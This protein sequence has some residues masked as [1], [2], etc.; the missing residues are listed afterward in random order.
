M[1]KTH[2][3]KSF[4]EVLLAT[5]GWS[6]DTKVRLIQELLDTLTSDVPANDND[7]E[8]VVDR[9]NPSIKYKKGRRW[10]EAAGIAAYPLVGEDAQEWVTRTRQEGDE[11]RAKVYDRLEPT[12]S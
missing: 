6:L 11:K 7:S 1:S 10:S 12:P 5:A 8:Y 2:Q 4:K 3:T 9:A